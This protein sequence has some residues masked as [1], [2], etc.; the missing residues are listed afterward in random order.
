MSNAGHDAL[1]NSL[2]QISDIPFPFVSK[3]FPK[4]EAVMARLVP[5]E[6]PF[7]ESLQL[8][9]A[10]MGS[11]IEESVF[12]SSSTVVACHAQGE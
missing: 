3:S 9:G 2:P 12:G 1:A 6:D 8:S 11:D 4:Q 7:V 10:T 5:V